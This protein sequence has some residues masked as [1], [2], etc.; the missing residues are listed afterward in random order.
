MVLFIF[1]FT[2]LRDVTFGDMHVV[3]YSS[4][5]VYSFKQKKYTNIMRSVTK[6]LGTYFQKCKFFVQ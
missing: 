6:K 4:D 5:E 3:W 2:V 1:F